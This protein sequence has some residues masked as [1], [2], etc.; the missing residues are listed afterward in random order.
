MTALVWKGMLNRDFGIINQIL[1]A[2][3]DWLGDG[4][5]A[6][7]SVLLVNLWISYAYML[8]V[9]TGALTAIPQDLKEAAFVDAPVR[10]RRSARSSCHC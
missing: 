6:K 10:S 8:L 2:N 4:T 9:V 7:F 1:G 3:I 5:L